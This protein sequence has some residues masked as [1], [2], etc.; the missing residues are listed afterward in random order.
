M[1]DP[2]AVPFSYEYVRTPGFTAMVVHGVLRV[3]PDGLALEFRDRPVITDAARE[4][5]AQIRTVTIPWSEIQSL[6]VREPWLLKPQM[7]LRSRSLRALD[8][9]P[10]VTGSELRLVVA[11]GDRALAREAAATVELA[12]AEHR[13]RQLESGTPPPRLPS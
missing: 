13:L 6:A 12:I 7:V 10:N 11:R 8:G 9:M 4:R 2:V 3:D 1:I 5:D